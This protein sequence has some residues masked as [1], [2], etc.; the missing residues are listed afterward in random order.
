MWFP[1]YSIF[2]SFD[3]YLVFRRIFKSLLVM[4]VSSVTIST[5]QNTI[6]L[7]YPPLPSPYAILLV[8]WVIVINTGGRCRQT[9][10]AVMCNQRCFRVN[11]PIQVKFFTRIASTLKITCNVK[12]PAQSVSFCWSGWNSF[13]SLIQI[14]LIHRSCSGSFPKSSVPSC[15]LVRISFI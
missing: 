6:Y 14:S 15:V 13:G 9:C 3:I 10:R 7:P 8:C 4:L 2:L 11:K 5:N 1:I 12:F